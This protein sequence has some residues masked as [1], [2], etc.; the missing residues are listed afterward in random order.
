[1]SQGKK[2]NTPKKYLGKLHH[3]KSW[4]AHV[5]G[6]RHKNFKWFFRKKK[7]FTDKLLKRMSMRFPR[8]HDIWGWD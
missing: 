5:M 7:W 4:R 8:S 1:M 6:S 3:K 2:Y